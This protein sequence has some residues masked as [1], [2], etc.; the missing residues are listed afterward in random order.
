MIKRLIKSF[1]TRLHKS[2]PEKYVKYLKSIGMQIGEN[3]SFL[4]CTK[5]HIDEGRAPF[6]KIGSNVVICTG[7]TILAHDYSWCVL[8][9]AYDQ[10][11]PTGGRHVVI[12][13]NVF[14]GENS[15]ILINVVIG[16]NCIIGSGAVVTKDIPDNSVC[17]GVP[18]K[19]IMT[20]D[21]YKNKREKYLLDEVLSNIKDIRKATGHIPNEHEMASFRILFMPRTDENMNKILVERVLG[22]TPQKTYEI[23]QNSE[24]RFSSYQEM[25]DYFGDKIFED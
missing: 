13:N 19:V 16:N 1:K 11:L 18:A 10:I 3:V 22:G 9:E 12:G 20:L 17:A 7:V 21:D 5:C 2:S 15:T 24:P 14:I 8:R 6:I 25:L 4:S 23:F